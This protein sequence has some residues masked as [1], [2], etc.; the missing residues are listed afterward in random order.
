MEMIAGA[1]HHFDGFLKNSE[2][3]NAENSKKTRLNTSNGR[4]P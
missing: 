2:A 4:A 1:R 3:T